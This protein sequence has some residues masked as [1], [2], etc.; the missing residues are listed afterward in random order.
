MIPGCGL[1]P[2]RAMTGKHRSSEV[3][4][5]NARRTQLRYIKKGKF[6][7]FVSARIQGLFDLGLGRLLAPDF[8]AFRALRGLRGTGGK[9]A[10]TI[11]AAHVGHRQ[12]T[13]PWM[14]V[15]LRSVISI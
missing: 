12:T 3:E 8:R 1:E 9:S 5:T 2:K 14:P 4:V 6:F 15:L 11:I 13:A 10:G 7:F